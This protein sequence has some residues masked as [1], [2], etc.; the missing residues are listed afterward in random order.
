MDKPAII[1]CVGSY[2]KSMRAGL[3][4]GGSVVHHVCGCSNVS[5][6]CFTTVFLMVCIFVWLGSRMLQLMVVVFIYTLLAGGLITEKTEQGIA[7]SVQGISACLER[8]GT[9][10]IRDNRINRKV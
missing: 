8:F 2:N 10:V 1:S 9:E 5:I 4:G 3:L 6:L 7:S